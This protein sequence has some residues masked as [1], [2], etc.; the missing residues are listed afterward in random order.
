LQF[1]KPALVNQLILDFL[2]ETEPPA[3]MLPMR[4]K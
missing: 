4:R 2:A 3:T 1:E